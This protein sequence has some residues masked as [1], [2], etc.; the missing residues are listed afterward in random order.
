MAIFFYF[1]ILKINNNMFDIEPV[2]L[3]LS[4]ILILLFSAPFVIY[5]RK[6]SEKNKTQNLFLEQLAS[7]SN[8]KFDDSDY[9]RDLYFIA[10]DSVNKILVYVKFGPEKTVHQ[11][12]LTKASD[13]QLVKVERSITVNGKLVNV[14]DGLT[15]KIEAG[16]AKREVKSLEFYDSELFSDNMG[17]LPLIQKWEKILKPSI[18][19]N[20][21]SLRKV[22]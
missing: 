14:I 10:F 13:I 1:Q 5:K 15:L 22:S 18:K 9:W 4:T 19:A 20:Q 7:G 11:I 12:D 6:Q 2:S 17:E 16:V 3:I 21:P 8:L